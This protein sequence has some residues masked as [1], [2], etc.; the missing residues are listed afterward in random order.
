MGGT[1]AFTARSPEAA[2]ILSRQDG[3]YTLSNAAGK[4]TH[5]HVIEPI[6]FHCHDYFLKQWHK[7]KGYPWA[8]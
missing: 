1:A 2:H 7:Y 6:G 3:L 8:P 4:V 5:G